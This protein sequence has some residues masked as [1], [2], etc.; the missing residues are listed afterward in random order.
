MAEVQSL[1][2]G[3]L[4]LLAKAKTAAAVGRLDEAV[5]LHKQALEIDPRQEQTHINLVSLYGR[6]K[7]YQR[8]EEHYRSAVAV[9][10]N[11]DE[12]HYNYAVMLT[13]QRRLPEAVAAYTRAIELNPSN[14]E[15]RNNLGYLLAE[16]RQFAQALEHVKKALESRPDYPQAHYNAGM[17]YLARGQTH[18]AAKH[19]EAAIR[20]NDQNAPRYLQSLARI[21]AATGD[22]RRAQEYEHRARQA[23]RA[24]Q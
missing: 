2:G 23:A 14:A 21:Y 17:I 15:A 11:R 18:Q 7:Q 13:V 1:S 20:P 5:L 8:A 19:L 10:P 4:P 22:S 9:N 6:L 3:I 12:A 16:Q 24:L